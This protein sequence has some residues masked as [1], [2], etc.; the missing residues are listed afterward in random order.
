[1]LRVQKSL[2]KEGSSSF[3]LAI[4]ERTRIRKRDDVIVELQR[5]SA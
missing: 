5:S 1:V 4:N 3:E 2:L